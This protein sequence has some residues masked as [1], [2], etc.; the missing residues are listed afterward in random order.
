MT[1]FLHA[2]WPV[3][4]VVAFTAVLV[5][6]IPRKALFYTPRPAETPEPFV[7]ILALDDEAYATLVRRMRM[8]WQ[9]RGRSFSG[10]IADS[11]TDP[12]DFAEADPPPAYLPLKA[13]SGAAFPAPEIPLASLMPRSLGEAMP[14]I[15]QASAD[16][17]PERDPSMLKV[18]DGIATDD[19]PPDF[20]LK[21]KRNQ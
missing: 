8:S 5:L 2:W 14:P 11:R 4:A 20:T 16:A 1:R 10:G 19:P 3:A 13:A 15:P 18:P 17:L 9:M 6:Q 12:F 7:S 21:R